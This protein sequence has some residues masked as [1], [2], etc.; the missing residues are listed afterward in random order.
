[1]TNAD[2]A[3]IAL[4]LADAVVQAQAAR[5]ERTV[6]AIPKA[7]PPPRLTAETWPQTCIKRD[8]RCGGCAL[9]AWEMEAER[10]H[11]YAETYQADPVRFGV[12]AEQR[13]LFRSLS[14]ALQALAE[15]ERHDRWSPSAMGPLMDRLEQGATH[16]QAGTNYRRDRED[17]FLRRATDVVEVR[18]AVAEAYGGNPWGIGDAECVIML[19]ARVGGDRDVLPTYEALAERHKLPAGTCRNLVRYGRRRIAVELAARGVIPMPGK[20][21]GLHYEVDVRRRALAGR[22]A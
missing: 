5:V 21:L 9:C 4:G 2:M 14:H 11:Q 6:D 19:M 20:G 10:W 16:G 22:C 1:M 12:P 7:P 18:R 13:F 17:P 15:W 3:L 8:V